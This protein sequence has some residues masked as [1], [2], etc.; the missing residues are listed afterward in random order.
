MSMLTSIHL[1]ISNYAYYIFSPI[2]SPPSVPK[3]ISW[4]EIFYGLI[5]YL[6]IWQYMEKTHI[7]LS[8]TCP[9]LKVKHTKLNVSAS[10]RLPL[11][12]E[13]NLQVDIHSRKGMTPYNKQ[14]Q[15]GHERINE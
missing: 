5:L 15:R 14:H 12:L 1:V 10:S 3:V 13:S 4:P 11:S 7:T 2:P 9:F 6:P 8:H